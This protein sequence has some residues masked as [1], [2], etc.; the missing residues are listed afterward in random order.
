MLAGGIAAAD[1]RAGLIE[2]KEDG[3]RGIAGLVAILRDGSFACV[4]CETE[5]GAE[6]ALKVLRKDAT[7]AE[8]ETLPDENDLASFLRAQ[9]VE[10]T[11]IDKRVASAD[12][13]VR[14]IRR[15]YTRPYLAHASIGPSAALAELKDGKLTVWTHSQGVFPLRAELHWFAAREHHG[16]AHGGR[17]MLRA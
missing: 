16:R 10:S 15:Q 13:R 11:V 9:P 8:G 2:L 1:S 12:A 17:R 7:W 3:A 14:T 6:A 4:V 5:N